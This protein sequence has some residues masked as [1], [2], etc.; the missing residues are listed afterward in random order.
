MTRKLFFWW[1][2]TKRCW[3]S[4]TFSYKGSKNS[5]SYYHF[6][7]VCAGGLNFCYFF[8]IRQTQNFYLLDHWF[9][10][11][12]LPP[13]PSLVPARHFH[14]LCKICEHIYRQKLLWHKGGGERYAIKLFPISICFIVK[15]HSFCPKL[16]PVAFQKE[17]SFHY[18]KYWIQGNFSAKTVIFDEALY[19]S[20]TIG[21]HTPTTV[22]G[23]LTW[24]PTKML[25]IM[26][27]IQM[28]QNYFLLLFA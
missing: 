13:P 12:R 15:K 16:S 27:F 9:S 6:K 24:G 19:F 3:S 21:I 17:N 1:T 26:K 28:K 20:K 4:C 18:H 2:K 11:H 14:I 5:P 23:P 10:G 25:I 22:R 8:H 7:E